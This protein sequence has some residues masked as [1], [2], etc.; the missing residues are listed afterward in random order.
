MGADH[1]KLGKLVETMV[2][3]PKLDYRNWR[4]VVQEFLQLVPEEHGLNIDERRVWDIIVHLLWATRNAIVSNMVNT[5]QVNTVQVHAQVSDGGGKRH[6]TTRFSVTRAIYAT[7]LLFLQV[8][9]LRLLMPCFCCRP[10]RAC[11]DA[12]TFI[13]ICLARATFML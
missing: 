6:C 10:C 9:R 4:A 1:S 5:V 8:A 12:N 2:A 3:L 11:F 7:H 13:P